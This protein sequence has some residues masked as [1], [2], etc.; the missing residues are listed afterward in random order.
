MYL[1]QTL[2]QLGCFC[3]Y[4]DE[5]WKN[6]RL[7]VTGFFLHLNLILIQELQPAFFEELE[8]ACRRGWGESGSEKSALNSLISRMLLNEHPSKYFTHKRFREFLSEL[9]FPGD[10]VGL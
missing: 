10:R 7:L 9:N 2:G 3:T 4:K 1:C 5:G 8:D 6:V